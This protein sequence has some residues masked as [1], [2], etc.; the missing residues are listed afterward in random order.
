MGLYDNSTFVPDTVP[1]TDAAQG[2]TLGFMD[3]LRQ[4]YRTQLLTAGTYRVEAALREQEGQQIAL[5]HKYGTEITPLDAQTNNDSGSWAAWRSNPYWRAA[6]GQSGPATP[7]GQQSTAPVT[8]QNDK[9]FSELQKKYPDAGFKTYAQMMQDV[10]ANAQAAQVDQ[11]YTSHTWGG[12]IGSF[13]G[14]AGAG[15]NLRYNGPGTVVPNVVAGMIGAGTGGVGGVALRVGGQAVAGALLEGAGA[16][17]GDNDESRVLGTQ[18]PTMGQRLREGFVGGALGAGVGEGIGAAARAVFPRSMT[19][20][21]DDM[22]AA[23]SE[24]TAAGPRPEPAAPAAEETPPEQVMPIGSR[25]GYPGEAPEIYGPPVAPE[26]DAALVRAYAEQPYGPS[27][28]AIPRIN[29][30]A[31][32]VA[33]QLDQWGGPGVDELD[34]LASDQYI[35]TPEARAEALRDGASVD[36]IAAR[37]DPQ[38]VG[39]FH[40]LGI[41]Q[42]NLR[43]EIEQL[44]NEQYDTS[45]D[46]EIT[47]QRQALDELDEQVAQLQS[48]QQNASRANA[49]KLQSRMDDLEAQR[50]ALE[51]QASRPTSADRA[52]A[53]DARLTEL[54]AQLVEADERRRDL[55]PLYTRAMEKAR[56]TTPARQEPMAAIHD[57]PEA[58]A[59]DS[60]DTVARQIDQAQRVTQVA[61]K[62]KEAPADQE[63]PSGGGQP[64]VPP[65]EGPEVEVNGD[66][67][68]LPSGRVVNMDD[69]VGASRD[70]NGKSVVDSSVRDLL[71]DVKAQRDLDEAS[72]SCAI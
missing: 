71:D 22:A 13:I 2:P 31:S 45:A 32:S 18:A 29:E 61:E 38:A 20:G 4:S 63:P 26:G 8:E 27:R 46:E 69:I 58:I 59:R 39:E 12:L 40:A 51:A 23:E 30:D 66:T 52:A 42:T 54:R 24:A 72:R 55:A 11:Q 47:Q 6:N 17:T 64:D 56:Q 10:A 60:A 3:T 49:R 44:R 57:T 67:V 28:D 37:I 36:E 7:M 65:A 50:S 14:S 62:P 9:L 48:Q 15:F 33:A 68:T 5:A 34:H 1:T 41:E 25:P 19:A 21:I 35:G 43:N 53:R 16:F 70:E